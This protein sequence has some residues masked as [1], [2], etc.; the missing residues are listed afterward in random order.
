MKLIKEKMMGFFKPVFKSY[1][2]AYR[3]LPRDVWLLSLVVFVNRCGTMVFFFLAL[4]ARETFGVSMGQAGFVITAYG[5][6]GLLGSYLGGRLTDTMGSYTVQK[7]SLVLSGALFILA[8]QLTSYWWLV[9]TMF[10]QGIVTEALHPANATAVSQVC[11]PELRTRGFALDRLAINLGI[12]VGPLVGGYLALINY[13]LLFWI[14]GL[15]C[16]FAGIIFIY[17]FRASRPPLEPGVEAAATSNLPVL[18]DLFFR[19]IITLTFFIGLI[20]FQLMAAFPIFL[21]S[22]YLLRENHLGILLTINTIIIILFE[23]LLMERLK[24]LPLLKIVAMGALLIGLGFGLMPLGRG[25]LFAAFTVTVWTV[26]EMLALPT[27]TTLIAN[28]SNDSTRGKYMGLF[29][30]SFSLAMAV[31]PTMGT[32]IYDI[33]GPD[34]L[35]FGCIGVGILLWFGFNSL[36]STSGNTEPGPSLPNN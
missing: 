15:T 18:K 4:Y 21:K 14:D 24:H 2:D 32:E 9:V 7:V 1:K 19:K 35:W 20:F 33:Y 36:R 13:K 8:G 25:F 27:L 5:F 3:G 26:G 10:F 31:G 29:S 6:G 30:F 34:T 22:V 17:F 12:S 23:M 11:S 16:L 28:H